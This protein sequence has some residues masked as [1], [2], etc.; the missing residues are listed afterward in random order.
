[1]NMAQG[2]KM[3]SLAAVLARISGC[4]SGSYSAGR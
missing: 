3:P 4:K 2:M 1:M